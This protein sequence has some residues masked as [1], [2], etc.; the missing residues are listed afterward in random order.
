MIRSNV[1]FWASITAV[2]FTQ[3]AVQEIMRNLNCISSSRFIVLPEFF[4]N[5]F[6]CGIMGAIITNF[7]PQF[8]ELSF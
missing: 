7:L 6:A 5:L 8:G 1:C 2:K 4:Q 3:T